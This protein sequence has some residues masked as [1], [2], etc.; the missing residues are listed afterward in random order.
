MSFYPSSTIP[1][2]SSVPSSSSISFPTPLFP[3]VPETECEPRHPVVKEG[4]KSKLTFAE[5]VSN[6]GQNNSLLLIRKS[7]SRKKEVLL[8]IGSVTPFLTISSAFLRR[9]GN[10]Q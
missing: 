4:R 2:I 9:L 7:M 6:S 1:E 8:S 3:L 10:S 5:M